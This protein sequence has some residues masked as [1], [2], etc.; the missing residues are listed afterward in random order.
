[1][2][3]HFWEPS[4]LFIFIIFSLWQP[5]FPVVILFLLV[6]LLLKSGIQV[7][8]KFMVISYFLYQEVFTDMFSLPNQAVQ[9]PVI[10]LMFYWFLSTLC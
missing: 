5:K 10:M 2:R 9:R 4:T 8:S 1:M 3:N 6:L 7:L